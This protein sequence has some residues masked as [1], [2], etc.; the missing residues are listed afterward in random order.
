MFSPV[1]TLQHAESHN[2]L[3]NVTTK[4]SKKI[5]FILYA[6]DTTLASTLE[7]LGTVNDVAHLERKL[8]QEITKVYSC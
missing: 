4:A 3:I 7:N 1:N 8:N 5:D 2:I 6:D